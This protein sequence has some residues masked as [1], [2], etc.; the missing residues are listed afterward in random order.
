MSLLFEAPGVKSSTKIPDRLKKASKMSRPK[1]R[2]AKR[3][4]V[5][6]AAYTSGARYIRKNGKWNKIVRSGPGV[7]KY[8][9]KAVVEESEGKHTDIIYESNGHI[10]R[11][12]SVDHRR[13]DTNIRAM[14]VRGP[15]PHAHRPDERSVDELKGNYCFYHLQD[16]KDEPEEDAFVPVTDFNQLFLVHPGTQM[17]VITGVDRSNELAGT[18]L[19]VDAATRGFEVFFQ[20]R[21]MIIYCTAGRNRSTSVVV[22][23]FMLLNLCTF[24]EA[25]NHVKNARTSAIGM[26]KT[27]QEYLR[28]VTHDMLVGLRNSIMIGD[29]SLAERISE[30]GIQPV[31]LKT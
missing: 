18:T 4:D 15:V 17:D 31:P 14:C 16:Q 5:L 28:G 23:M 24:D 1:P 21:D 20:H 25:Y 30:T 11:H 19:L 3:S 9:E 26:I 29:K 12:G 7:P 8:K 10:M 2:K 6:E 22:T 13:R 27:T